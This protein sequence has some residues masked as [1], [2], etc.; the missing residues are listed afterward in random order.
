MDPHINRCRQ[1][2]GVARTV[3]HGH[4]DWPCA[5]LQA[6]QLRWRQG[7]RPGSGSRIHHHR[8]GVTINDHS[9]GL[10]RRGDT[11][12]AGNGATRRRFIQIQH[13]ITERCIDSGLRQD[14]RYRREIKGTGCAA[15]VTCTVGCRHRNS[16]CVIRQP[17]Q[18]RSRDGGG[19]VAIRADGR[20]DRRAIYRHRHGLTC[21][22]N[23]GGAGNQLRCARFSGIQHAIGK[24]RI[25][26]WHTRLGQ[27]HIQTGTGRRRVKRGI[28]RGDADLN[29]P[30]VQPAEQ[31]RCHDGCP[32][33]SEGVHGTGD[34]IRQPR[35][36][37]QHRGARNQPGTGTAQG[38]SCGRF[39]NIQ[40][41]V[42]C[43]STDGQGWQR[44]G[45]Q[46]ETA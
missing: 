9:H 2:R 15:R 4:D 19:P 5:I 31:T 27:H 46:R 42:A 10:T 29:R 32:A 11:G 3:G 35:N 34:R 1:R 17:L 39:S 36:S 24:R 16:V 45:C 26:G 14:L 25:N 13:T 7:N 44:M 43:N 6:Q 40:H 28:R 8:H 37:D 20:G 30:V 21:A 33:C 22:G 38:K 12:R 41:A 18:D 23:A